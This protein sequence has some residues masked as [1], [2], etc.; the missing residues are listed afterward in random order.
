ILGGM[1]SDWLRPRYRLSYMLVPA[2][3]LIIAFFPTMLF[4][5]SGDPSFFWP[6]LF[7]AVFFLFMNT[8]PLNAAIL[9]VVQP[10][11]RA[12]AIAL[13]ILIIHI[14]GDALSPILIGRVSD[15]FGLQTASELI[16]YATVL[17]AALLFYGARYLPR[18]EEA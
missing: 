16:S 10:E 9:N 2:V 5:R 11:H 8:G 18:D 15:S 6:L 12:R 3:S 4:F 1:I 13:N 14:L 17:A 7:L